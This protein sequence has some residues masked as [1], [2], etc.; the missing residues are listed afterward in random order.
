LFIPKS[1]SLE[2]TVDGA[3]TL[4]SHYPSDESGLRLE[5]LLEAEGIAHD[6]R[7]SGES[8]WWSILT[9]LL[10]FV[11]FFGFWIFLMQQ[12]Q[13]RGRTNRRGV[14]DGKSVGQREETF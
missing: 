14:S 7:G 4:K 2:V 5:E 1:R 9:Y 13:G 3:E 12:V 6:S 8:A 10:P 11:L